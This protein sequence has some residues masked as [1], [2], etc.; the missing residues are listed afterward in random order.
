[1]TSQWSHTPLTLIYISYMTVIS[2]PTHA[3]IYHLYDITVISHPTHAKIYLTLHSH[4]R[5]HL[6]HIAVIPRVPQIWAVI[7]ITVISYVSQ[8]CKKDQSYDGD[9]DDLLGAVVARNS[10][11]LGSNFSQVRCLSLGVCGY[12]APNCSKAWSVLRY[13]TLHRTNEV[14]WQE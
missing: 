13:C 10:N 14:I 6:H 4:L 12:S 5:Y 1:M 3:K 7:Y 2:H 11:V 9:P 8:I